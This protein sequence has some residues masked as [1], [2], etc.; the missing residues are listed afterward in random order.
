MD[1]RKKIRR[2]FWENINYPVLYSMYSKVIDLLSSSSSEEEEEEDSVVGQPKK[3]HHH[4]TK[5]NS[6]TKVSDDWRQ[7]LH[8]SAMLR[9]V[10]QCLSPHTTKEKNCPVLRGSYLRNVLDKFS[11]FEKARIDKRIARW[12]GTFCDEVRGDTHSHIAPTRPAP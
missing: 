2:I 10:S 1:S 4:D 7:R 5:K 9:H 6:M 8:S 12:K 3:K 11:E